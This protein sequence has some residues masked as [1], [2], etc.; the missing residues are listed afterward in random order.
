MP[1]PNWLLNHNP[2]G[3]RDFLLPGPLLG[4]RGRGLERA[5]PLGRPRPGSTEGPRASSPQPF[6]RDSA[7]RFPSKATARTGRG[8]DPA[9]VELNATQRRISGRPESAFFLPG[10]SFVLFAR[11]VPENPG[12]GGTASPSPVAAGAA[13]SSPPPTPAAVVGG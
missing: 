8:R 3:V 11:A 1:G 2:T 5:G 6:A 4:R 9:D 12:A 7:L 13:A 10:R